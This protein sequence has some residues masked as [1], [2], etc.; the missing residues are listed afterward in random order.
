MVA[1]VAIIFGLVFGSFA[2]V[3][4]FRLPRHESIVFP[5]SHCPLCQSPIIW[6][7]NVPLVSYFALNGRC[8]SCN[9]GIPLRYPIVEGIS[10]VLFLLGAIIYG[11]NLNGIKF[12]IIAL[13]MLILFFSDLE[14]R[15]L[16]DLITLPLIALG[17]IFTIISTF[18]VPVFPKI[19]LLE[20]LIGGAIGFIIPAA[21]LYIYKFIRGKEGLGFG[22]IKLL[23]GIGTFEG[24][25]G[26]LLTLILGSTLGI[27]IG[28]GYMLFAGKNRNYELPFGTFLAFS[29]LIIYIL[30]PPI[31]W[32]TYLSFIH[33]MK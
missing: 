27:I 32:Q 11:P 29:A 28:G 14:Q 7:D 12:A 22:D 16:P 2:N 23:A 10:A 8:R 6:F 1:L 13:S 26:L 31:L 30:D 24:W 21:A 19:S 18:L 9:S 4:I 15:I 5:P 3:L 25:E 17:V 33:L 20:S